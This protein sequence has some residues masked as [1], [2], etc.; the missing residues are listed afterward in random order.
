MLGDI[1]FKWIP[2]TLFLI[3]C[4]GIIGKIVLD[5]ID[6][7]WECDRTLPDQP[8]LSDVFQKMYEIDVDQVML[9]VVF[10]CV[11]KQQLGITFLSFLNA[12]QEKQDED[13]DDYPEFENTNERNEE[14]FLKKSSTA[15]AIADFIQKL[16]FIEYI[17]NTNINIPNM[18]AVKYPVDYFLARLYKINF[19]SIYDVARNTYRRVNPTLP[20]KLN[21][22]LKYDKKF[23]LDGE[24]SKALSE[25]VDEMIGQITFHKNFSE[26]AAEVNA[27]MKNEEEMFSEL[28]VNGASAAG[29]PY[30]AGTKRRDVRSEAER[31]AYHLFC[32]DDAFDQYI[33]NQVWYSTGRA[34]LVKQGGVD[35]ARLVLYGGFAGS[36]IGF[37]YSQSWTKFMNS[38]CRE[39]SAV[40]MSWMHGGARKLAEFFGV[41]AG[42]APNGKEFISIDISEW[43][44][45][46]CQELMQ[47]AC[48]FHCKILVQIL[49]TEHAHYIRK[50]KSLY[51][52]MIHS[53]VAIP[54]QHVVQLHSGMKSGWIMTANDNT[55]MHE[56]IMRTLI[57][58][59][60]LPNIKRQLYGDDN[61]CLKDNDVDSSK[62]IR[63]YERFGLKLSRF[64][65]SEK[66]SEVD[67]LSKFI[68]FDGMTYFPWRP[69]VES[70][71][72][73][74]M[75]EEFEPSMR[76]VP[77]ARVTAEHLLG[78]LFDNPFNA[79]VRKVI[80]HLLS[81]IKMHHGIETVTISER[82]L[83][84]WRAMGMDVK[85]MSGLIP[86]IPDVSFIERL[87]EVATTPIRF[88][89][90]DCDRLALCVPKFE[91][92]RTAKQ[93]AYYMRAQSNAI[94]ATLQVK[95]AH[96][97]NCMLNNT[98][99]H[100][101][102]PEW[103]HGRAGGKLVEILNSGGIK[104]E[105]ILDLGSHPGAA[106]STMQGLNMFKR[107]VCVSLFPQIDKH[108]GFCPRISRTDNVELVVHDANTYSTNE[109][110]DVCFDDIYDFETPKKFSKEEQ[111]IHH[112]NTHFKD[113]KHRALLFHKNVNT[114]IMKVRGITPDIID[115][116]Y[117]IY[118]K[119]GWIDIRK[120]F[121]SY[122]WSTELYV[123]FK[124]K[125]G[126]AFRKTTF[127]HAMNSYLN[128]L[129]PRM[130]AYVGGYEH[131][132]SQ[133][134]E[135]REVLR[136]PV[137]SNEKVQALI[138]NFITNRTNGEYD[139]DLSK[140][141]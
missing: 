138:E 90:S 85:R 110:F 111:M 92:I 57:K 132:Y 139:C 102:I 134:V 42:E 22:L 55:L 94:A 58:L 40:G 129:V 108:K 54:G 47:A 44:S 91:F 75:P 53:K 6:L 50:F 45:S 30:P 130:N 49:D 76:E 80:Y 116:L 96:R 128:R 9:R 135:G 60:D 48:D 69:A 12:K 17:G 79:E 109:K 87:Y 39:W 52:D 114:Y 4:F 66:L 120:P 95:F 16:H 101:R 10:I 107:A 3:F 84:K 100:L 141:L 103:A 115:G 1:P 23:K 25:T 28:Q 59:G 77:D 113:A 70:H 86:I 112:F 133:L 64:H 65:V 131:N 19:R 88:S 78:H 118:K 136:N 93:N 137:N 99:S 5:E 98:C 104:H 41:E 8:F 35:K 68:Q 63:G 61:L 105:S 51:M 72:R 27:R 2:L 46:L 56:F 43:D 37:L 97:R 81:N 140:F 125:G 73:L 13:I 89:W 26:F 11:M 38:S 21:Q 127:R 18:A 117:D 36:L 34:K 121:F 123:V 74:L 15:K 33:E 20:M 29:F 31:E 122:A 119:Y 124:K 62:F 7:F 14:K 126:D 82:T 83:D 106:I 24:V 32:E 71:A 67:F